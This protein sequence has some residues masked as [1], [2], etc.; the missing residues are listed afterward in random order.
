M[1]TKRLTDIT[2]RQLK[3]IK[4]LQV[5]VFDENV[6]GFGVRVSPNGTKSYFILYRVGR[7]SRRYTFG[8]VANMTLAEARAFAKRSL[9]EV[10][11]GSDPAKMKRENREHY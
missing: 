3:P 4:G 8:R 11:M 1:P 5:D 9:I 2:V 7:R 6:R 10:G